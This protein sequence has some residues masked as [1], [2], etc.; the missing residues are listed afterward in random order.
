M[1]ARYGL[2]AE[3]DTPEALLAAI[4]KVR[5]QATAK[6]AGSIWWN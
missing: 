1:S 6:A 5:G 4:G 3:F 2:L